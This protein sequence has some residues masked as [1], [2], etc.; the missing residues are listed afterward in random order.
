MERDITYDLMRLGAIDAA[1]GYIVGALGLM[2]I[3]F[4]A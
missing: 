4:E 2:A 3:G 1:P